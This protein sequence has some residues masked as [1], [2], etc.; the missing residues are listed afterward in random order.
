MLACA[1]LELV[2][3]VIGAE[4]AHH[5][6]KQKTIRMRQI[7]THNGII[8]ERR[9]VS[10]VAFSGALKS[11]NSAMNG[12]QR[13]NLSSADQRCSRFQLSISIEM[14]HQNSERISLFKRAS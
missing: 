5:W 1:F 12:G 3:M 2:M 6:L 7:F 8:W 4:E 13:S 10:E 11:R 14:T 9:E